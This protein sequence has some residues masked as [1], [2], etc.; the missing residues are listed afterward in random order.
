MGWAY[1]GNPIYGPYGYVKRSGGVVA[2]MQSGYSL[3][4]PDQRPPTS[5]YPAGFFVEDYTYK[6]VEDPTVLDENNGRFCIT[7]EFPEGTYAYC[8]TINNGSSDSGGVF[9]G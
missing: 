8:T 7:P 2:Q 5:L 3:N 4:L 6:D 1:D 9:I